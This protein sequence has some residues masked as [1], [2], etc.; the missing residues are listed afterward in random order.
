MES[1]QPV[2]GDLVSGIA[3][4]KRLISNSEDHVQ[5]GSCHAERQRSIS[6]RIGM[7]DASLRLWPEFTLSVAEGLSM[8]RRKPSPEFGII[9]AKR[10]V[11]VCVE[12]RTVSREATVQ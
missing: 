2:F 12:N 10:R 11:A 3:E 4:C 8:T 1:A 7:R 9:I 6:Y 5:K